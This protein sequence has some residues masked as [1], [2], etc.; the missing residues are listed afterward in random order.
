MLVFVVAGCAKTPPERLKLEDYYY[1]PEVQQILH[2]DFR[3][4]CDGAFGL[5]V[6][7]DASVDGCARSTRDAQ[8]LLRVCQHLNAQSDGDEIK[9]LEACFRR[10]GALAPD[11]SL[12]MPPAADREIIK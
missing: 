10:F 9:M 11:A 3:P 6:A 7:G 12:D 5:R 8:V 2:V 1:L 4:V